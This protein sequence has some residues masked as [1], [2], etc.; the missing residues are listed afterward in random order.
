M[1]LDILGILPPGNADPKTDTW[2]RTITAAVA[3]T[4]LASASANIALTAQIRASQTAQ[5]S[6]L[7]KLFERFDQAEAETIVGVILMMRRRY[8]EDVAMGRTAY[9]EK[10]ATDIRV[11]ILHYQSLTWGR[12]FPPFDPCA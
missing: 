2:Q 1:K 3:I 10:W 11:K 8:C 9:A 4:F 6:V 5:Q 7:D 12:Q